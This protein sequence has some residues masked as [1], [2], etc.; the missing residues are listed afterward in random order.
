MRLA[1]GEAL[2]AAERGEVPVG[3]VLSAADGTV[4]AQ[5]G[6]SVIGSHD[7]SAHAEI[8]VLRRAGQCL[9]NYRLPDTTIYVTLEPCIMCFGALIHARVDRLVFA[10]HD[11][12]TGAVESRCQIGRDNLFNHKIKVETGVMA[13]ECGT[14]LK[15][16]FRSRRS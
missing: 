10:A 11:P 7:P 14:L 3:A 4:L 13:A 12:K 2:R 8:L 15:N 6:N 9:K 5:A 16:F 1:Y